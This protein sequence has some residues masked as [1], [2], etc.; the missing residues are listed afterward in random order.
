[1]S[2]P[3]HLVTIMVS[4]IKAKLYRAI[5]HPRAAAGGFYRYDLVFWKYYVKWLLELTLFRLWHLM[6]IAVCGKPEITIV[7]IGR[8][9][10]Y[11][12]ENR[13]RIEATLSWNLRYIDGEVIYVEWNRLPKQRSDAGWLVERF[14]NLRVYVVPPEIHD[15]LSTNPDIPVMEYFAKNVGIRR[16]MTHGSA[17]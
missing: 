13:S 6:I 12:G 7:L 9:D 4:Y 14:P 15:S 17:L 11:H 8:S 5:T 2:A 16:A 10:Y 3:P 1:M